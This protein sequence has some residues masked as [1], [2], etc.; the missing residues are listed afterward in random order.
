MAARP[1]HLLQYIRRLASGP[2]Q[3]SEGELL[4]CFIRLRDQDAFAELVRRHGPMVRTV[5][6]RVLGDAHAA[7]DCFQ[8]TFLVLARKAPA[9]RHPEALASWLHGVARRVALKC[10][11]AEGRRRRHEAVGARVSQNAPRQD[12]LDELT[13]RELLLVLDEEL[14]RLPEVYRLPVLLC[15]LEGR[16]REEA[17]RQL[18]WTPDSLRSRLERGRERLHARLIKRGLELSI[19]LAALEAARA[20]AGAAESTALV[21]VT[22]REAMAFGVPGLATAGGAVSEKAMVLAE[23]MMKGMALAKLRVGL[24]LVLAVGV[25]TAG[26]GMVLQQAQEMKLSEISQEVGHEPTT[27]KEAKRAESN[28]LFV[29]TDHY[30]DPL[31]EGT[32]ARM[33]SLRLRHAGL[34]DFVFLRGGETLISAG[35]SVL[36]F[37]DVPTGRLAREVPLQ[38]ASGPWQVALS[39]NGQTVAALTQKSLCFWQAATG[40]QIQKITGQPENALYLQFSPD[41][42]LL[43]IGIGDGKVSLWEWENKVERRLDVPTRKLGIDSAFHGCFSPDGKWFVVG[44]GWDSPL[45]VYESATGR[46]VRRFDCSASISAV[47]P[48]NKRLAVASMKNDKGAAETVLRF[49]ELDSGKETVQY[50]LGHRDSYFSLAFSPD[51]KLLACGRSY[52]SCLLDC[53]SGRVVH[54]FTGFLQ[55]LL[56][57]PDGKTLSASAGARIRMWNV[58]TG[59]DRADGMGG[60]ELVGSISP[61]GRI[62]AAA[63]SGEPAVSLWDTATGR[64]LRALPV[65]EGGHTVKSLK[66]VSDGKSLFAGQSNSTLRFWDVAGGKEQRTVQ[67]RDENRPNPHD[68]FFHRFHVSNDGKRVSTLEW[69]GAR[70][71]TRLALWDIDSG[72]L[73]SQHVMPPWLL[74]PYS[75]LETAWSGDAATLSLRRNDGLTQM[76]VQSGAIR[77][78]IPDTSNI[79]ALAASPD[80]RLLAAFRPAGAK[81]K[82]AVGIWEAATGKEIATRAADAVSSL[83]L[84]PD[85]RYLVATDRGFLHVWDLATGKERRRWPLPEANT[86]PGGN[87]VVTRLLLSPDGRRAFTAMNDGTALVWDLQPALRRDQPLVGKPKE[88]ELAAW[89]ADLAGEDACRAYAALWRLAEMPEAAIPFLRR[90]L[91]PATNAESQA[92]RQLI[93]DLDS[94]DF[95][96]REKTFEQ[97]AKLGP[98]A[99][100]VL[101]Q[102]LE[103]KP[104]PEARRRMQDLLDRIDQQPPAGEALRLL[105]ALHVLDTT[106]VEGRRLLRELAKG[107]EGAWLTQQARAALARLNR[108]GL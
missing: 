32:I 91:Q 42:K 84:T 57:A 2:D 41:G 74:P 6:R 9:V 53:A 95:A 98:I 103:Q 96:I 51:G 17:A 39:P 7:E 26:A 37:W 88:K 14:Q 24:A 10:R 21:D 19:A 25:V 97:L 13:A 20:V 28:K 16:S 44:G 75:V 8:A 47:S 31:P 64:F 22:V 101:Q 55:K 104:T 81:V 108:S 5:C 18:G 50:P 80:G 40:K 90:H 23:R 71:E 89:W 29:R 59:R 76:R 77:Y 100:P 34:S 106:G 27:P 45:G 46:Q 78:R 30:G 73:L 68:I 79:H 69:F 107:A 35:G 72:K 33:G 62:L 61:D 67:L 66:F 52:R 105:R 82:A 15:C 1:E 85:N 36:R 87:P 54:R 43:A 3:A 99:E 65:K 86:A 58:A 93:A 49:F 92:I 83:A 70:N 63:E 102:V 11:R 48:D 12:P 4:A 56:F 38:D 94:N 60:F